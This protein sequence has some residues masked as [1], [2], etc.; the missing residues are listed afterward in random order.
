MGRKAGFITALMLALACCIALVGCAGVDKGRYVGTWDLE[1]GSDENLTA[2]SIEL[3][4]SLGL[5]VTLTLNEDGTGVLNLFGESMNL[6]WDATSNTEGA[7]SFNETTA[8]LKLADGKLMLEDDTGSYMAFTPSDAAAQSGSAEA[9]STSAE[10]ASGESVSAESAASDSASAASAEAD[11]SQADSASAEVAE[12][13]SEE[14]TS[15]EA[16]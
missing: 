6:T 2:D 7:V 8:I 1:S 11:S 3:M 15:A 12:S 4:K 10:S 13:N 5:D 9:S 16:A 14:G